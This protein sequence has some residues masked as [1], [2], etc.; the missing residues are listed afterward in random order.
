MSGRS[1]RLALAAALLAVAVA[2]AGLVAWWRG[3]NVGPVQR[4]ERIAQRS[5]CFGCHGRGGVTGLDDPGDGV[6]GVPP[7]TAEALRSYAEDA[8]ELREWVRDG[9]PRRVRAELEQYPLEGPDPLFQMPAFGDR[10]SEREIGDVA[11]WLAAVGGFDGPGEG[12]AE[13]GLLAAER[14]G[15]FGCHGPGGRGDTPNPGSLKG[16][17]PAW[18]GRDFPELVRNEAE[19]R[20]WILD[21]APERLREHRVARWFLERQTLRMPAYRDRIRDSDVSA[22]VAYVRWLRGGTLP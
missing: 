7:L 16:Y 9:M 13:A 11:S 8:G 18:D 22:I 15:C 4:G 17:V 1:R 14:L 12:E 5:G 20:A 6:G 19:L 3:R 10:L 21:G 2:A